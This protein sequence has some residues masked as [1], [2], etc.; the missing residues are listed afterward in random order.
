MDTM[1][2]HG[3]VSWIQTYVLHVH[4]HIA[5]DVDM[6]MLHGYGHVAGGEGQ[7]TPRDPVPWGVCKT[8]HKGIVSCGGGAHHGSNNA[9]DLILQRG[10]GAGH[11][12]VS[13]LYCM[14]V[15]KYA[16]IFILCACLTVKYAYMNAC[17]LTCTSMYAGRYSCM[18][19]CISSVHDLSP[20]SFWQQQDQLNEDRGT[21]FLDFAIKKVH[22]GIKFQG[23]GGDLVVAFK[24]QN[25]CE[26]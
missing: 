5:H 20:P 16:Y 25:H 11:N 26:S 4:G 8:V 22:Q 10:G 15:C 14:F 21:L 6:G 13:N 18:Q 3:H 23:V 12:E 2:G 17:R 19:K 1:H 7:G 9:G 24:F